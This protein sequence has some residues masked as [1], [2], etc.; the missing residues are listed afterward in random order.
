MSKYSTMWLT[1]SKEAID[2]TIRLDEDDPLAVYLLIHYIYVSS[3]F[4]SHTGTFEITQ[5]VIETFQ[6]VSHERIEVEQN[7][8]LVLARLYTI[9]DKFLVHDLKDRCRSIFSLRVQSSL[10][11]QMAH[12][13]AA[14]RY[15][16]FE[17]SAREIKLAFACTLHHQLFNEYTEILEPYGIDGLT[18]L[19]TDYPELSQ[20]ALLSCEIPYSVSCKKSEHPRTWQLKN[21]PCG[22]RHICGGL[23]RN[24]L[25]RVECKEHPNEVGHLGRAKSCY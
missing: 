10:S 4:E 5:Q 15:V 3:D 20:D 14:A 19:L 23:C 21:C 24:V 17:E 18:Q 22:M 16:Y 11:N 1:S 2:N 13:L 9:A 25:E 7:S 8:L 6:T 12:Y